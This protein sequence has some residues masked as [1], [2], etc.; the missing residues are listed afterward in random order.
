MPDDRYQD[1]AAFAADLREL[2][3]D[4]GGASQTHATESGKTLPIARPDFEATVPA[5]PADFAKTVPAAQPYDKTVAQ[6]AAPSG[7]SDIEI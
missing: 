6:R 3:A 5:M 4:S 1:G 2:M 7:V